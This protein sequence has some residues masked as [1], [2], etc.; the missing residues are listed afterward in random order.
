MPSGAELVELPSLWSVGLFDFGPVDYLTIA[1]E[2]HR[3][4]GIVDIPLV[5][6]GRKRFRRGWIVSIAFNA[7]H[8]HRFRPRPLRRRGGDR[9]LPPTEELSRVGEH[10]RQPIAAAPDQ[11]DA[12]NAAVLPGHGKAALKFAGAKDRLAVAMKRT[13]R[14]I[15]PGVSGPVI[16][17]AAGM[18]YSRPSTVV[19]APIIGQMVSPAIEYHRYVRRDIRRLGIALETEL[20][21]AED[22]TEVFPSLPAIFGA[23]H[24]AMGYRFAWPNVVTCQVLAHVGVPM[25]A[26][27]VFKRE[28]VDRPQKWRRA[29]EHRIAGGVLEAIKTRIAQGNVPQPSV[30]LGG[31][32][33]VDRGRPAPRRCPRRRHDRFHRTRCRREIVGRTN[34][35][36]IIGG[37][38]PSPTT[39]NQDGG[40]Q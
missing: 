8:E 36:R 30:G 31:H 23:M 12:V 37:G 17:P 2:R 24:R 40:N 26:L 21:V 35:C 15:R 4:R 25:A 39:A 6:E 16:R 34:R 18:A 28:P 7:Q 27:R 5:D 14:P 1:I 19:G 13:F 9:H 38:S 10:Q 11:R 20:G 32:G 29:A 33:K 22:R 3:S